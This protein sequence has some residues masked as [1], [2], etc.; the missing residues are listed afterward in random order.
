MSEILHRDDWEAHDETILLNEENSLMSK[1]VFEIA[2]GENIARR[3]SLVRPEI[4]VETNRGGVEYIYNP[5]LD[6]YSASR[7]KELP[8]YNSLDDMRS[9]NVASIG[10][11][12]GNFRYEEKSE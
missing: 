1:E 9:T 8:R 6:D 2:P 12:L 4:N 7:T 11:I 10:E 5:L 3:M